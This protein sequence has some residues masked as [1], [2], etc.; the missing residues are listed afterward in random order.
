MDETKEKV[1]ELLSSAGCFWY[2]FV[3]KGEEVGFIILKEQKYEKLITE[4]VI[5]GFGLDSETLEYLKSSSPEEREKLKKVTKVA[6][7]K[8]QLK[9]LED[10]LSAE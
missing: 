6:S 8:R 3:E 5:K 1:I 4:H 2:S 7:L 9:S 10:E